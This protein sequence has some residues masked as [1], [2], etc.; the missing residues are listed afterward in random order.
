MATKINR[1]I[2]K[3]LAGVEDLLIGAGVVSQTRNGTTYNITKLNAGTLP[4]SGDSETLDFVSIKSQIDLIS[5]VAYEVN[6]VAH[7]FIPG[8]ILKATAT[9]N[10]Y[11]KAQADTVANSVVIGI[12]S[13]VTDVDNFVAVTQRLQC[14]LTTLQ[15]DAVAGTTGGLT[16]GT[17]YYLS[18]ATAGAITSVEPTISQLALVALNTTTAVFINQQQGYTTSSDFGVVV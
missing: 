1:Y 17:V 13:S 15:W 3:A 9:A 2:Q 4:Y 5:D 8:N 6:Q 11:A 18:G 10:V 14:T 7:G 12:V 16:A